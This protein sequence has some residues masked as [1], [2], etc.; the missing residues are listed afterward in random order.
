LTHP[1]RIHQLDVI[2]NVGIILRLVLL[3]LF[4]L[5]VEVDVIWLMRIPVF[6][7]NIPIFVVG[8]LVWS[9]RWS[10]RTRS[11][12]VVGHGNNLERAG[13]K[14]TTMTVAKFNHPVSREV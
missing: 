10:R 13:K 2:F 5:F 1:S 8:H 3:F 9:R 6:S 7:S 14:R 11:S 4:I 12:F